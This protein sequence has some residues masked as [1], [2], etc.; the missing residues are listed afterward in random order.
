MPPAPTSPATPYAVV[1]RLLAD[2]ARCPDCTAALARTRCDACGLDV[3]GAPGRQLW[4][5]SGRAADALS[6][7]DAHLKA[8]RAQQTAREAARPPVA[9]APWGPDP[10]AHTPAPGQ[11]AGEPV[12][13]VVSGSLLVP[14]THHPVPVPT[15]GSFVPRAAR[16]HWRVQTVL[17]VLGAGLL[18]AASIVF[19]VFSWGWIGLTGRAVTVAVGTVVV[20]VLAGRL[21]RADLRSS[22]EAVGALGTVMLLLDAWAVAATGL[23][24]VTAPS[25]YA[26]AASLVCAVLLLVGGRATHLRVARVVGTALLPLAPVLLVPL[27]TGPAVAAWLLVASVVLA[28]GRFVLDRPT[29]PGPSTEDRA[30]FEPTVL[31]GAAWL[32]T[33]TGA[34]LAVCGVLADPTGDGLSGVGA[35]GALGGLAALQ[36]RLARTVRRA[37]S[38][39]AAMADA[40]WWATADSASWWATAAGALTATAAGAAA[41]VTGA[42]L[43]AAGGSFLALVPCGSAAVVAVIAGTTARARR[44]VPVAAAD[45]VASRRAQAPTRAAEAA[46]DSA[47]VVA[48]ILGAPA[49]L[50]LPFAAVRAAIEPGGANRAVLS[51]ASLVGAA[52]VATLLA[53]AVRPSAATKPARQCALWLGAAVVLGIP[54]AAGAAIP[55]LARTGTVVLSL[56]IGVAAYG[57]DRRLL[58]APPASALSRAPLRALS[59]LVVPAALVATHGSPWLVAATLAAFATLAL[60]V[61]PWLVGH[62]T[63][64]A[65]AAAAAV[66]A[67]WSAVLV[68]FG[69]AGVR[70]PLGALL[71]AGIG[72]VLVT[73]AALSPDAAWQRLDRCATL[74][75]TGTLAAAGWTA[76]LVAAARGGQPP[77]LAAFI[78]LVAML[79]AVA[80]TGVVVGGADLLGDRARRVAGTL[81]A[82]VVTGGVVSLHLALGAHD[83]T[84]LA[85]GIAGVG[86]SSVLLALPLAAAGA[87]RGRAPDAV[88]RLVLEVTGWVTVSIALLVAVPTGPGG[89]ALVLLV[90]AITAGAWSLR[91]DRRAARWGVLVLGAAASWVLLSAG[92]VGVPEAYLAP[93]G[94]VLVAVGARRRRLEAPADVPLLAAGLALAMVPTALLDGVLAGRVP[95]VGLTLAAGALVVAIGLRLRYATPPDDGTAP[96]RTPI[97]AVHVLLLIGLLVVV[98][99][100]ARHALSAAIATVDG[101]APHLAAFGVGRIEAWSGSAALVVAAATLRLTRLWPWAGYSPR[102]WGWWLVAAV[103]ATPSLVAVDGTPPGFVRWMLPLAIGGAL[104]VQGG[105][106]PER[107]SLATGQRATHRVD[108]TFL[109]TLGLVLAGASALAAAARSP[110]PSDVP[111]AILGVVVIAAG[112]ARWRRLP[113]PTAWLTAPWP[114]AGP[115]LL[116]PAAVDQQGAW[117]TPTVLAGALVLVA[118]GLLLAPRTPDSPDD[119]HHVATRGVRDHARQ[120]LLTTGAMLAAAGPGVRATIAALRGPDPARLLA[121][122]AWSLPAAAVIGVAVLALVRAQ[123][124]VIRAP[125]SDPRRWG[126]ALVLTTAAAPTLLAVDA[127]TTGL[128][129]VLAAVAAAAGLAVGGTLADGGAR[130]DLG[131]ALTAAATVAWT[132]RD[133][134]EPADLPIV[135]AGCLLLVVG[136]LDMAAWRQRSS[137]RGLGLGLVL[138]L[139]VPLATGWVSPTGWRLLLALVGAVAAVLVGA[140]HR[141]QAPFAVGGVVLVLLTLAQLSPAAVAALRVVEW[142]MLLALGGAILLGLGLTYERRLREAKEAVRFVTGMR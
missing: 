109:I 73:P 132:L 97:D 64:R 130:R 49:V 89:L 115:L 121:V 41:A 15:T 48:L 46:A 20:F 102:T 57:A 58:V 142:W 68:G 62:G 35:L 65:G 33:V 71:A 116:L 138:T 67:A 21:R 98:V 90:G 52:V 69:A 126:L 5:L 85:A 45:H 19:L 88:L 29:P 31:T 50:V 103:A 84:G 106:T 55:P 108:G 36:V 25:V 53:L 76:G 78:V 32:I 11:R 26:A 30:W 112:V 1:Q 70:S 47:L 9:M 13:T 74:A 63:A 92:D 3:S 122:E 39:T 96:E 42:R 128:I 10:S 43:D 72:L 59:A 6:L 2:P 140:V 114:L 61:R 129:R 40:G 23:V 110:L 83:G 123:P 80:V 81:F 133:G 86:A 44:S 91:P 105:R 137:W 16:P 135:I 118:L 124:D 136:S 37:D 82:A 119:A 54:A 14:T 95:R 8:M 60:G 99:G 24:T 87:Q 104:A 141:W 120:L 79:A 66:V 101:S 18:A 125:G 127:S 107:G 117:R 134:P 113:V 34:L 4:D 131:L 94:L 28:C 139:V 56:V 22:A 38:D 75:T 77:A 111:V 7:R 27:T 51:L 12:R 100:P 93:A 17:Q